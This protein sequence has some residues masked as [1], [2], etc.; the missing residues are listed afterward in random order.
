[1]AIGDEGESAGDRIRVLDPGAADEVALVA[2]RMRDTLIEVLGDETG[3]AMYTMDWL[4]AR[5]LWHLDASR[6]T[7]QVFLAERADGR[8]AG[9]T[10]VRIELDE[11]GQRFGLFA[12][13]YVAPASRKAGLAIALL[14]H[15]EAWMRAHG[16]TEAATFTD[17]F[18]TKLQKL[19]IGR[20]YVMSDAGGGFVRLAKGL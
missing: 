14:A 2:T 6:C 5:V 7:G 8:V 9:H 11:R 1:M 19:Y 10:I 15:G 20:G 12:T 18:N 16:L 13:T 3:R 17:T 4:V